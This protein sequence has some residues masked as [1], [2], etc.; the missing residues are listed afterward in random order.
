MKNETVYCKDCREKIAWWDMYSN[1][2]YEEEWEC[3]AMFRQK[4]DGQCWR[5]KS[6]HNRLWARQPDAAHPY[7]VK[8][9]RN[10]CALIYNTKY[11]RKCAEKKHFH[12]GRPR[13]KGLLVK[14]RN[15]NGSSTEHTHGGF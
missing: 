15:K 4:V 13:C 8:S 7:P 14:V 12:C 3:P 9:E 1:I 10:Y 2:Q 11:C 5:D 6:G